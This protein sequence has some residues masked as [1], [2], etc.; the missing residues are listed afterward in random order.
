MA[1]YAYFS[2][3]K[4]SSA[5]A[6]NG[7]YRHNYRESVP[8]N[9]NPALSHLND[10]AVHL[11][12]ASYNAAFNERLA[13]LE[14]YKD[15]KFRKDGV[16]A[17]ELTLEY[18]PEAAGTF[19]LDS[20]KKANVEW[21]KEQFG[22]TNVIS[23]VFHYDEGTYEGTGAIH[24]H[25]VIIPEDN[26]G[27]ICARSFVNGKGSLIAM[28][29][30]YADAMKQ[31]GL[32]RGLKGHHMKH[33]TIQRM[34]A[35][36]EAELSKEPV[37][38]KLQGESDKDYANRLRDRIED[39]KAASVRQK[40]LHEKEIREIKAKQKPETSKDK[41]IAYL[42]KENSRLTDSV[43]GI[44]REFGQRGGVQAVIKKADTLDDLNYAIANHPDEELAARASKDAGKLLEWAADRKKRQQNTL[45]DT[46]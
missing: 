19:D 13:G 23:V 27:R 14:Y 11:D 38:V 45:K 8:A 35:R 24:G 25:A 3:R 42:K 31:F 1:N 37:P 41:E 29:T 34:Y 43:K 30:S 16:R 46:R 15:H 4:L 10:E 22:E 28:Q 44:E 33:E 17:F 12:A 40:Y 20:W 21:L 7:A 32:E 39:M 26:R 6:L 18:S 2:L 36:T 9:V 5:A